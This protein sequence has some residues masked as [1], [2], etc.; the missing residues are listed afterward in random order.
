M[1]AIVTKYL[2]ATNTK[3]SRIKATCARGSLTVSM[4]YETGIDGEHDMAARA[5]CRKFAVEDKAKYGTEP[6]KNPWMKPFV[7]GCLPS[8]NY[9]HVFTS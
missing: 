2:P 1:Q 6:L 4:S 5:L 7:S 9:A 8:G 3:P